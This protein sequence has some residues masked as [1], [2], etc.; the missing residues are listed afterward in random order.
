MGIISGFLAIG[1]AL[2][3]SCEKCKHCQ[4]EIRDYDDSVLVSELQYGDPVRYC[5][6]E[7]DE[8]EKSPD[9]VQT[10]PFGYQVTSIVCR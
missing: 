6:D 8:I 9:L 1:S 7:L 5:G 3:T 4:S 10:H 2:F